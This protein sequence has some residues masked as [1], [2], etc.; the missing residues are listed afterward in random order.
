M[1][2][3]NRQTLETKICTV[4]ILAETLCKRNLR[5]KSEDITLYFY[6]LL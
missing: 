6:D 4:L 3:G 2:P 5:D 1:I